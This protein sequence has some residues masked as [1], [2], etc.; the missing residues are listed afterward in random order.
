MVRSI[1]ITSRGLHLLH[2]CEKD[3]KIEEITKPLETEFVQKL[4]VITFSQDLFKY[5]AFYL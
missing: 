1:F 5:P 4:Q 2:T 3:R